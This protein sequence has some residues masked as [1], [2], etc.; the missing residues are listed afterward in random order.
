MKLLLEEKVNNQE[1]IYVT[2]TFMPPLEEYIDEIR[3]LWDSAWVTNNGV[4]HQEFEKKVAKYLKAENLCLFVN[5]HS[6][7]STTISALKLTGE[8]IT[9]PFTFAST[10]HAIVENGLTPVFCDIN[11]DNYTMDASKIEALITEKTSAILP[12][13]VYGNV[14]NTSEIEKIARKYNLKV[15][16][17][18]AHAFGIEV[19]GRGIATFGDATMFSFHATKVFHTVEGGAVAFSDPALKSILNNK[20]NFGITSPD[21]VVS[22]GSNAKMCELHAAMG[23]VN[24]RHI[25]KQ[26]ELRKKDS[27]RYRERLLNAPGIKLMYDSAG[28]KSNYAY[29]P[30]LIDEKVFG[31]SRD[32]IFDLLAR[33]NIHTRKYFYPLTSDYGCY[34]G[35]FDSLLT[36]I[37]Q[38]VASHILTLPIYG[39]LNLEIVDFICDLIKKPN[40]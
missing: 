25:D 26:I 16:Y 27:E 38:Y 13:H 36:P 9:T 18:A 30:V 15:I 14:C 32:E 1:P 39:D 37:A 21:T 11:P 31:K 10:T 4:L 6:A 19:N 35:R 17:D 40:N 34:R 33:Q 22:V 2:R 12:V 20:K 5:G 29:F 24:L 23:L 7:L 8:V 28:I 3:P